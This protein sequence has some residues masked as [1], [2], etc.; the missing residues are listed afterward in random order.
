[1]KWQVARQQG[2]FLAEALRLA[3]GDVDSLDKLAPGF[4]YAHKGSVAYIGA[5][6]QGKWSTRQ[7][8]VC[9]VAAM[10]QQSDAAVKR[11]GKRLC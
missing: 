11:F 1:M 9:G 3:D 2:E 5:G 7:S 10:G 8:N 6:E 4:Q